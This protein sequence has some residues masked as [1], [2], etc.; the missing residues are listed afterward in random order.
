MAQETPSDRETR[1]SSGAISVDVKAPSEEALEVERQT[2]I[3][4]DR[5]SLESSR[6][7]PAEG[8]VDPNRYLCGRGDVFELNFWGSQNFKLRAT[9]DLEGRLFV[10]KVGYVAIAGRSL[11]ESRDLVKRAVAHYYPGLKF[12]LTLTAPRVFAVHVVGYV[13]RPGVYTANSLERVAAL[14]SRAGGVSGSRRRI[15]IRRKGGKILIADLTLYDETGNADDNPFLFDGDIIDVPFAALTA[16]ISGAVR[17]PGNYELVASK[18]LAELIDIAGGFTSLATT[19][20]PIQLVRRNARQLS[21]RIAIRFKGDEKSV[22]TTPL[23]DGDAVV[24]PS[25]NELQP[26][27]LLIGPVAGAKIAD[28]VTL[29]RRFPYVIGATVRTILEESGGIGASADLKGGY[30]RKQDG[31]VIRVDLE[32]LLMRRDFSADRAV[33]VGDTI[34][35]PQKRTAV[36]VQGSVS[37]P[38]LFPYNP[39]F[40]GAQYLAIAGGPRSNARR[41]SE[42]RVISSNGTVKRYSDNLTLDPGDT[43]FVPE[44]TFSRSEIVQL[45]MGGAGLLISSFSLIYL[46][47]TR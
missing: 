19:A 22:P 30:I 31:A 20:L 42:Y 27:V 28:E 9:V 33:E 17:R 45:V 18:D 5:A 46:V 39:Q 44:R 14:L 29:V 26:S 32:A 1:T 24:V 12:D 43:I 3:G 47:T 8:P 13:G 38:D 10:P 2:D 34:V 23:K 7:I 40:K 15:Q 25:M 16:S 11:A 35:V 41:K 6:V 21:E 37:N 4:R 36:S